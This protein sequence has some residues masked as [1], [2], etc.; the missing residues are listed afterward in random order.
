MHVN[1]QERESKG[2]GEE[3]PQKENLQ[4]KEEERRDGRYD[5]QGREEK[6]RGNG[7][8]EEK[9]YKDEGEREK[10][11]VGVRGF[12]ETENKGDRTKRNGQ[13]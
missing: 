8:G 13:E 11:K 12:A 5:K 6:R 2:Y 3:T 4:E 1:N 9:N 7:G 10:K